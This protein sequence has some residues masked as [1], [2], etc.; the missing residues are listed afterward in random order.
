[1]AGVLGGPRRRWFWLVV[2][3][4]MCALVL[5]KW[6]LRSPAYRR[7]FD[8]QEWLEMRLDEDGY[9]TRYEMVGDLLKRHRLIGMKRDEVYRLL[10]TPYSTT[11]SPT[12]PHPGWL[13]GM[14]RR[15]LGTDWTALIIEFEPED[16]AVTVFG[17]T[18]TTR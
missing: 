10:G 1:M 18:G 16:R 3:L 11:Y 2:L 13:L 9:S 8:R 4:S 12:Y 14:D 5:C 6:G 17:P 7:P 15:L